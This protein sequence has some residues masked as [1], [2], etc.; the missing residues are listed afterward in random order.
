[1]LEMYR[2]PSPSP[3]EKCGTGK[4]TGRSSS[5]SDELGFFGTMR[6]DR[7]RPLPSLAGDY[8]CQFSFIVW[9]GSLDKDEADK[10]VS[11]LSDKGEIV[12]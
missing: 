6:Y 4:R 12:Q 9:A 3:T 1:M 5:A 10:R 11:D 8:R 2:S 7:C